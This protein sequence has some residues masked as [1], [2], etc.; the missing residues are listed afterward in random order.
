MLFLTLYSQILDLLEQF[1][2]RAHPL[3][4]S[5]LEEVFLLGTNTLAYSAQTS[6]PLIG[7]NK[8]L[9]SASVSMLCATPLS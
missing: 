7:T 3:A 6:Y 8:S 4:Y 1:V 5:V 2:L 9:V